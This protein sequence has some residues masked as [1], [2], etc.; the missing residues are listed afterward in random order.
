MRESVVSSKG[1]TTIPIEIRRALGIV[2]GT[3]LKWSA[4]GTVITA[5]KKAGVLNEAQK[6]IRQRAASWNSKI[7]GTEL[8]RRT[9]S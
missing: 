7:S 5:R 6:H 3:V 1:T 8:L 4:D 9:R 2:G